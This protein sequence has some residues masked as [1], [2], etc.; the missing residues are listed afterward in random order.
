MHVAARLNDGFLHA[1]AARVADARVGLLNGSFQLG[2]P[3]DLAIGALHLDDGA[4]GLR[5]FHRLR[6]VGEIM[7]VA[8]GLFA[9]ANRV[10]EHARLI[11]EEEIDLREVLL[12]VEQ[13]VLRAGEGFEHRHVVAAPV[14]DA[15][16]QRHALLHDGLARIGGCALI[17]RQQRAALSLSLAQQR[18][19]LPAEVFLVL[20]DIHRVKQL[21]RLRARL[22]HQRVGRGD[23]QPNDGLIHIGAP[24]QAVH[25]A[26]LG[27]GNRQIVADE[28][29]FLR[30]HQRRD[31]RRDVDFPPAV[32]R[33][34]IAPLYLADGDGDV[35]PFAHLHKLADLVER[36]RVGRVHAEHGFLLVFAGEDA[37]DV[38]I[39]LR[40]RGHK[41]QLAVNVLDQ[42]AHRLIQRVLDV[43]RAD[44]HPLARDVERALDDGLAEQRRG[45][46]FALA[47][48]ALPRLNDLAD[49]LGELAD[50]AALDVFRDAQ[51]LGD[52]VVI[53]VA[54]QQHDGFAVRAGLQAQA[55][56]AA[57]RQI[58]FGGHD[59]QTDA[60][61]LLA[62]DAVVHHLV[63]GE[64][65]AVLVAVFFAGVKVA[66][67]RFADFADDFGRIDERA[68][69]VVV[70]FLLLVGQE[71]IDFAVAGDVVFMHQPV[72]RLL[73]VTAHGD[74]I[75]VYVGYH[76]RAE[77]FQIAR[78]AVHIADEEQQLED[79]HVPAL[80]AVARRRVAL[81][82]VDHAADSAIQKRVYRVVK[83]IERNERALVAALHA[84]RRLLKRGEHGAFAAGE[85]L[86]GR[87]TLSHLHQHILKQAELIR[88]KRIGL[89][90]LLFRAVTLHIRGRVLGEA[91]QVAH[92]R[93][94]LVIGHPK[95]L[96]RR[97]VFRQNTPLDDLVHRGG[98]QAQPRVE[99]P[100]YLG[101]I[102]ALDMRHRVD[103]L[104]TGDDDPHLALA[105][106]T[107][108][109]H[110]RLQIEHHAGIVADVLPD[111][112]NQE[113]EMEIRR[114][115]VHIF[116]NFAPQPLN[117][118]LGGLFAVEP[119]ARGV[120]A[121]ARRPGQRGDHVVLPKRE[122]FPRGCPRL[123]V[124]SLKRR[125]ERLQPALPVQKAF[126]RRNLHIVAVIAA[127]LVKHLRKYPQN[128]V[129]IL[130]HRR[131]RVDVEQ[132]R[133]RR[134]FAHPAHHR[135]AQRIKAEFILKIV[136]GALP[137][138]FLVGQQIR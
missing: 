90:K 134:H 126:Q 55:A 52:F 124:D 110:Q 70:D 96:R 122:G 132:N 99:A 66:E 5:G 101:K 79:I 89:H 18:D 25:R 131:F 35:L 58:G 77:V 27:V 47:R 14:E 76:Q 74:F 94:I 42:V 1:G 107:Q 93:S 121:H 129:L 24:S 116:R 111:F 67:H 84:L 7:A 125:L 86:A 81:R 88:H 20:L 95:Q 68:A 113:H 46:S 136:D 73:N 87:A 34:L 48:L 117:A 104:L 91:E 53:A 51:R 56:V 98:G 61:D 38:L 33:G 39:A 29:Q 17:L 82:P 69:D 3:P 63:V 44:V 64:I 72:K 138:D 30:A 59:A 109:L 130:A 21:D 13:L 65:V 71:E 112:I 37:A 19:D 115:A 49:G 60:A 120:L 83:A 80:Q 32:G 114:F 40:K 85:M 31:Q 50:V 9:Q 26:A 41:V 43:L 75:V 2:Q 102:V 45:G 62:A 105:A 135:V 54:V 128:G 133:L 92:H 123:G 28:L 11:F 16:D 78:H 108:L 103:V 15:A 106:R 6:L 118:H 10:A 97:V 119:V 8:L 57:L 127:M 36:L 137:A 100:L 12:P 23:A 22:F 4:D